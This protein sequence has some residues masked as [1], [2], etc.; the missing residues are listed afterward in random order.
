MGSC[1]APVIS[2]LY[3]GSCHNAHSKDLVDPR[4]INVL[5]FV[6]DFLILIDATDGHVESFFNTTLLPSSQ[7]LSPLTLTHEFP[8]GNSII[9]L[10]LRI[11]F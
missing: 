8:K 3:L 6:H 5:C 1:I 7:Y 11:R 10:D 2:D 4:T 9:F